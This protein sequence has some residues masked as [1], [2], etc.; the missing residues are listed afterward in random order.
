VS[1]IQVTCV[2]VLLQEYRDTIF[3]YTSDFLVQMGKGI[4]CPIQAKNSLAICSIIFTE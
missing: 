3:G 4:A 1:A 2:V